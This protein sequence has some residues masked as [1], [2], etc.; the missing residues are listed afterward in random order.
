MTKPFVK[1]EL[2]SWHTKVQA[3]SLQTFANCFVAY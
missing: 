3:S 2:V 1:L